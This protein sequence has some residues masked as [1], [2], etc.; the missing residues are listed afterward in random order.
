VNVLLATIEKVKR[1]YVAHFERHIH[2]PIEQVWAMLTENEN[3][4]KWFP[5]LSVE[6]LQKGSYILFDMRN[7]N[8]E[9]FKILDLKMNAVLEFSWG[10]DIVRFE[11]YPEADGCTLV[12]NEKIKR[13]TSHTPRDLAGWHVCLD[14][15]KALVEGTEV[16]S[17]EELWKKSVVEYVRAIEKI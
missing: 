9:K 4:K 7:G 16:G 15:V 11:L 10:E 1:F 5:E 6:E 17:R 13:I 14:V 8:F 3:L 2:S 12:L